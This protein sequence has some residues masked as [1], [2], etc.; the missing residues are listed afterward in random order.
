MPGTF[1]DILCLGFEQ[2]FE[3]DII[4]PVLQTV[5]LRLRKVK[6][7]TQGHMPLG[8]RAILNPGLSTACCLSVV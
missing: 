5:K 2:L 1:L 4:S 7:P 3:A 6:L 8:S